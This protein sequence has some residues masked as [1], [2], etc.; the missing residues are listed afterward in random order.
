MIWSRAMAT[1]G[2]K[3][4]TWLI[5]IPIPIPILLMLAVDV[6]K[7]LEFLMFYYSLISTIATDQT[8]QD[9]N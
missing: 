8:K 4:I 5:T 1:L 2:T 6:F 3:P 9:S 7:H